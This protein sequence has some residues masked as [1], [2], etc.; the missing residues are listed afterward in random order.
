[1]GERWDTAVAAAA[2]EPPADLRAAVEEELIAL[3]NDLGEALQRAA[4]Q[5]WPA[6]CDG[7]VVRIVMLSRLTTATPWPWIPAPLL[8]TGIYQGILKTAG[9]AFTPPPSP[10]STAWTGSA[11]QD[12]PAC[13]PP[14][15]AGR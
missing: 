14:S 6:G 2:E 11:Q 9:I 12:K 4:G 10:G 8:A 3:W 13:S 7:L 15:A 5:C 1:V